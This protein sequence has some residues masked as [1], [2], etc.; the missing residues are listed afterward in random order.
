MQPGFFNA[1]LK[2]IESQIRIKYVLLYSF[3]EPFLHPQL[4]LFVHKLKS[5]HIKRVM[6]STNLSRPYNLERVMAAGLDELRISVSGFEQGEYFHTGRD[7]KQFIEACARLKDMNR[8]GC[9]A[10]LIFHRYKTNQHE[11][12]RVQEFAKEHGFDLIEE[13]AFIIPFEKFI[14]DSW[15]EADRKLIGHLILTPE[16]KLAQTER[17]QFCYYQ[18]QQ[19]VIDANGKVFLCRHVFSDAYIVGDIMK[20]SIW[21]IR[22]RMRADL[23]CVKC[24]AAGLNRYTVQHTASDK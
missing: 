24:K 14:Y 23:F 18:Q 22:R 10:S 17:S 15:T 4:H 20:D 21:E 8:H 2:R 9:K 19:I 12:P 6:I 7:M 1:M 16:Q 13:Q 3:S 11:F 5:H